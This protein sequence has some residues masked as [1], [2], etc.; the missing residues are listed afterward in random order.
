MGR[1][2]D[3]WGGENVLLETS[4]NVELNHDFFKVLKLSWVGGWVVKEESSM[5]IVTCKRIFT[6]AVGFSF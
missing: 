3:A 5:D 6:Y 4:G 2:T 1:Q